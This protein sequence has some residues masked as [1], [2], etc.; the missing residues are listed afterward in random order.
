[1]LAFA[2]SRMGPRVHG[3]APRFITPD[4]AME[5]VWPIND[6]LLPHKQ[7][8]AGVPYYRDRERQCDE[9]LLAFAM[10]PQ[11]PVLE[12]CLDAE[13]WRVLHDRHGGF[14]VVAAANK[15][16]RNNEFVVIPKGL[17]KEDWLGAIV[18]SFYLRFPREHLPEPPQ[19]RP[20]T[21]RASTPRAR[22]REAAKHAPEAAMPTAKA[23]GES[24]VEQPIP[25]PPSNVVR[26]QPKPARS[27]ARRLLMWVIVWPA[28][29]VTALFV[30]FVML[31][32]LGV[33]DRPPG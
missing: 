3:A 29:A 11:A 17:P 22:K 13:G 12:Q 20:R 21:P 23:D 4:E 30:L 2:F 27:L 16:G 19:Q 32:L 24:I 18:L 6:L 14:L 8:I 9:A 1:M 7:Q 26:P 15:A 31:G 10:R 5:I 28:S 33:W 25:I